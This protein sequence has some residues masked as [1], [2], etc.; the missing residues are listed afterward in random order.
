MEESVLKMLP[1]I[2]GQGVGQRE[3]SSRGK[4]LYLNLRLQVHVTTQ[5]VNISKEKRKELIMCLIK[6][7]IWLCQKKSVIFGFS[8]DSFR[9]KRMVSQS[10]S[11][12][13]DKGGINTQNMMT[14]MEVKAK[15]Y[16]WLWHQQYYMRVNVSQDGC[17]KLKYLFELMRVQV[18]LKIESYVLYE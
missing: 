9:V 11:E 6:C 10:P 7:H 14:E 8:F 18:K 16:K 1:H 2:N 13:H 3:G 17:F 12:W 15:S 5:H 4:H